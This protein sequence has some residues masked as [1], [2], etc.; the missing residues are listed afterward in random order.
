MVKHRHKSGFG[1]L[2]VQFA[3]LSFRKAQETGTGKWRL[4][5]EFASRADMKVD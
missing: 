4:T 3:E 1:W 5:G 2:V